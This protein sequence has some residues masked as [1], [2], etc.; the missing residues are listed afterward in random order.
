MEKYLNWVSL[1]LCLGI[2]IPIASASDYFV[3][4]ELDTGIATGSYGPDGYVGAD[5]VNRIIF[6]SSTNTYIYKVSI[7]A[8]TDPNMHPDNPDA[9]GP[10]APRTFT[11]EKSFGIGVSPGHESEFYVDEQNNIIYLGASEGIRKY[12]YDT[13]INNY[14]FDSQVAPPSPMEEGYSTQSLAYDPG[15][16]TWY[17]GS[18]AWNNNPGITLRDVWKYDG[19]QGNSGTWVLAFQ[20]TTLETTASHHDG[21][22]FI[23]G[24][25][26]LA[27]YAGDYVKQYTTGGTLVKK[28]TYQ[29]LGHE[30][31]GMGFS[32]LK[33]FWAGSHGNKITEF[34]GGALQVAIEGIPDQCV[35]IGNAFNTFDL[36]DY[37]IG[38][39]PFT[40]TYSGNT[41][42]VV[43][44]DT[45][46]VAKVTYPAGWTGSETIT[47]TVTDANGNT[48]NDDATFTVEAVP[49]IGDIPDQSTPFTPINLDSYLSGIDA[50]KVTWT[51][52][53][54]INFVVNID[55]VTHIATVSNPSN[56]NIPET[57]TFTTT[58]T[59]CDKPVSDSDAATFTPEIPVT[60]DIKPGSFP[61]SINL[62][63]G[64]TVPVAIFSTATFDAT[65]V[66]PLTVT[67]AG[68]S[69]NLKGKGTPMAAFE[70]VNGDGLNDIV[71]HVSTSALVLTGVDTE[72][73][74]NGKT[75]DGTPIRGTDSV[76][77]VPP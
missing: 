66:D 48:A 60:I 14:V 33:H 39:P 59:C 1:F 53:G 43:S 29:P 3:Y 57:I 24:H 44:I 25:L 5:G 67:L 50:S 38:A 19:S 34:G 70:D 21:M 52:S 11:F 23:N 40:W 68:A 30:L 28:F 10:I 73:I 46:N 54:N 47:F 35:P 71:V 26:Y 32:A 61:N 75:L 55:P 74:L 17:A 16:N 64:G 69:V 62:G 12:V 77:I 51:A 22:E 18:I 13:S 4:S 56:S 36:D 58:A 15:T 27:D 49:V 6:Y 31:E 41:A 37:T 76:R 72:A 9:T 8:G 7:P 2:A 65:N 42:L 63:N 20:Y 45:N